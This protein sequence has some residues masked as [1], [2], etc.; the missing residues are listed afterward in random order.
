[1]ENIKV[2]VLLNGD[3]VVSSIEEVPSELG[4]PDCKLTN[5]FLIK[6]SIN[7]DIFLDS[8]LSEYTNQN[9][10]MIHSDKILTLIEPKETI[11][12]KYTS[13]NKNESS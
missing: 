9:T 12:K 6:K 1:M 5:S 3:T 4:E 2:L 11:L 10:I 13:L 8:W 7:D